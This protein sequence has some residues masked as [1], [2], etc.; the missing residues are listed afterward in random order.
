MK[1]P[2]AVLFVIVSCAAVP[3]QPADS[4][5][6]T[7]GS[8]VQATPSG[9]APR[10]PGAVA[11]ED[12]E[13]L[14]AL[15]QGNLAEVEAGQLAGRKSPSKA[16]RSFAR[17]MVD[18]HSATLKE[19]RALAARLGVAAPDETDEAHRAQLA[20]L[21]RASGREFDLQYVRNAGVADHDRT[22]ALLERGASSGNPEIRDFS[23]KT[24]RTVT[25]H[26]QWARRLSAKQ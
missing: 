20:A 22:L 3:A 19:L 11:T 4:A 17:T 16:I 9:S 2:R 5:G 21:S 15:V 12:R 10:A 8:S 7:N 6:A 23:R 13:L 25:L 1:A 14:L 18:D 26:A 24:L